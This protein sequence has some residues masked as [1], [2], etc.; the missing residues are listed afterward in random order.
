MGYKAG[1]HRFG[2]WGQSFAQD[3][4]P[5][6][7]QIRLVSMRAGARLMLCAGGQAVH[8]LRPPFML[9]RLERERYRCGRLA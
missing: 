1:A 8:D 9:G 7:A 6:L 4:S 2:S 3:P 5:V